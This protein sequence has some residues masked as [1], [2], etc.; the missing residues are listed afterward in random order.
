M[1]ILIVSCTLLTILGVQTLLELKRLKE[2]DERKKKQKEID[3]IK[4]Q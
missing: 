4:N 2:E 3:N 1:L